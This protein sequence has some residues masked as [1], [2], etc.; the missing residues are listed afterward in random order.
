MK[1]HKILIG[2]D[3]DVDKS[4]V[5]WMSGD[6]IILNNLSFF[7]IYD[8]LSFYREKEIKPTV[9]VECGFLNK[10]NWHAQSGR[11]A[12]VNAKIGQR[13]GENFQVAKLLVQMCKHLA[14]PHVE[15]RPTAS[16]VDAGKFKT[17]TGIKTRTNQEQRDAAMLIWGR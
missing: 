4:G 14:I 3:P 17:I 16:K 12:S 1:Q 9:Y 10:S 5:A 6:Q 13:T 11:S 15:V 7:E 2:I 8:M